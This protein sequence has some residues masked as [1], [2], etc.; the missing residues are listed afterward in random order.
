MNFLNWILSSVFTF[1]IFSA[2]SLTVRAEDYTYE[3]TNGSL[4]ITGYTGPGGAVIIPATINGLPVTEI[5]YVAFYEATAVTSVTIPSGVTRIGNNAFYGCTG[6]TGVTFPD[7]VTSF[8]D[9]VFYGCTRLTS[10][11]L[12]NSVTRIGN[13]T[14]YGCAALTS[15]TIPASVTSIGEVAFGACTSLTGVTLPPG[16]TGISYATFFGCTSLASVTIPGS[17]TSIGDRAFYNCQSLTGLVIPS[18]VTRIGEATFFDCASLT[19]VTI[20]NGVTSIGEAAFSGCAILDG[21]MLPNSV[22]AI[23]Q[24][25]FYGCASLS[26]LT[27]PTGV[28]SVP[29]ATFRGC[30]SLTRV[31]IPGSV[32][33]LDSFA[34]FGCSNLNRVYF[35]GNAPALGSSVFGEIYNLTIYYR[36]GTT[37]WGTSFD[38]HPTA[39]MVVVPPTLSAEPANVTVIAGS[40]ATFSVTATGSAPAY[41]WQKDGV[42]VPGATAATLVLSGAQTAQAG[43]YKVWVSNSSGSVS[44]SPVTLTVVVQPVITAEPANVTVTQGGNATFSVTATGGALAYQWKK[45]EVN[46]SGATAATLV[47]SNV[48]TANAGDYKVM[49]SNL[50]GSVTSHA[51]ILTVNLPPAITAQPVSI[52]RNQGASATFSVTATGTGVLNYRWNKDGVEIPGATGA[53]LEMNNLQSALAGS[54]TVVVAN[55]YGSVTSDPATLTVNSLPTISD[56]ADRSTNEDV[57][58]V[59]PFTVGDLETSPLSL[60]LSGSSSNTAL[61]PNANIVF[62]GSVFS[63]SVRVTP[64]ANQS[65]TVTITVIVSDGGAATATDTFVLTVNPVND[66]PTVGVIANQSTQEDL[67]TGAVAFA[68]GDVE[69]PAESLTLGGSSSNLTLVPNANIVF[70]GGG[71]NRTVTATPAANQSGSATITVTVSDEA[72]AATRT[73]VL[74]VN[75][76][77]DAPTITD[78]ADLSTSEDV[79]VGALKFTVA[80]PETSAASLVLGRSSSNTVLVPTANIVFGGSG[81]NRTVTVTPAA[82][83]SGSATITVTV[84]DGVLTTTDTFL[85]TVNAVNDPPTIG[86][87][88]NRS[89]NEDVATAPISFTVADLETA[90]E[91]LT[92]G[93][94]SSNLT[95]LPNSN[96]GFG[97]NGTNRTVTLTPAANQSGSTT[98]TLTANDGLLTTTRTFVLTVNPINDAPVISD[99]ADQ[100]T[101]EDVGTAAIDFTVVD[102]ETPASLTLAGSS[103]NLVLVPNANIVF[104]GS[105]SNRTVTVT[106]AANRSGSATISVTVSDGALTTTDTFVLTVNELVD[107]ATVTLGGLAA[108]YDG[109]PKPISA[110]TLPA[111]LA[112]SF[113]YDGQSQPPVQLGTYAVEATVNDAVYTGT[114]AGSLVIAKGVQ[115]IAF[116]PVPNQSL[117]QATVTVNATASSGL[118]PVFSVVSGPATLSGQ[119]LALTGPGLVV[120]QAGQPG[121]SNWNAAPPV[122]RAFHVFAGRFDQDFQWAKGFGGASSDTASGIAPDSAGN[123]F[124][125]VDFT[126]TVSFG[127]FTLAAAG[128]SSDLALLKVAADGQV[129]SA[130]RFGGSN[131]DLAKAVAVDANDNAILAGEFLTS[132]TLGGVTHAAAGSKDISLLK[133]GPTGTLLWSTRFGGTLSDSVYGLAVDA[134]GNILLTGDFSGSISFGA[135]TLTSAG[136]R[137]GFVAKLN[138]SGV[139][140]WA[141][142]VGGTGN[143]TAFAA[144]VSPTGQILVG[145]SFSVAA[146]F[147]AFSR[148]SA[149]GT[150]G[151][152]M[153]VSPAGVVQWVTRFGGSANDSARAVA[154]DVT[155]AA[156]AAGNFAGTDA[157]FGTEILAS[158]GADDAFVVRLAAADGA[159]LAVKPCG[160][161]GADAGLGLAA[162]PFG[163]LYLSGSYSGTAYFDGD[164]LITPQGPDGFVAKLSLEGGFVWAMG[165]SGTFDEKVTSI[166]A[167]HA[168]HVFVAGNFSQAARLGTHD[169]VGGGLVD[170]FVAKINGPTPSFASTPEPVTVD[171]GDPFSIAAPAAGVNPITYQWFKGGVEL[172]GEIFSS[173]E[174]TAASTGDQGNYHVVASNAYGSSALPPVAVNVRVP[175]RILLLDSPADSLENRVLEV[176]LYLTSQGEVT[177]LTVELPYD[178]DL[179]RNPSFQ[180]GP[181][182]VPGNSSVVVDSVAGTIRVVAS[183]F[184]ATIPGGK[185]WI[186]T[187]LFTTRSVPVG[188]VV[189]LMP[190]LASISDLAGNPLPGYTKLVKGVTSVARRGIPGD[191]NNNGR[192]DVSDAAELIRLYSYPAQIRTWDQFL[193]DLNGDGVLTEGDA[194][195]VLRVV[196]ELDPT[197]SFPSAPPSLMAARSGKRSFLG[198]SVAPIATRPLNSITATAGTSRMVLTR[199]TGA[200]TNK[201]L[202]RVYLDD[203]PVGQAGVSFR[204]DY[205]ASILRITGASSLTIPP[206]GLPPG[207][208]PTWNVAPGNSFATQTGSVSF[209]AAWNSSWSFG[210]GQAVAQIVFEVQSAITGQVVFPLTLAEVNV[211]PH[212]ADG[213]ASPLAA[214]GHVSMFTRTYA[215]WALANLGDASADPTADS[216]HD[217]FSNG[218]EFSASTNPGDAR[219]RLQTTAANLT[220]AGFT[221]RWFAAYGVNYRVRWTRDFL[222]WNLLP[223]SD[224]AGSGT[225]AEITDPTPPA[226]GRF[227]RIEVIGAP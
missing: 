183:A 1:V 193:N 63:R 43:S 128:S 4:T 131:L 189:T 219:S 67:A 212:N 139:P 7:S 29:Y 94:S 121:D 22:A 190:A 116:S 129:L 209:A 48:Q 58:T 143:D 221:L 181:Y 170:G 165:G 168:G 60:T 18:G 56:I 161:T 213:P 176:P 217:G 35:L 196:A 118:A 86:S 45:G 207:V 112:V 88:G 154:V 200:D 82:N 141:L 37:G 167:N 164:T 19:S 21:I 208:S 11:A 155:G 84:S 23:G 73:F 49:A 159:F 113:T 140:L 107:T 206:G 182:L 224:V 148:T 137:D 8:G 46:V 203:V 89:T 135:T 187:F 111:G 39:Q 225:E 175:D 70:G 26:S 226:D 27:L 142:K 17:V 66:P 162:D 95:L 52:T 96:I 199:L 195:R 32:T 93:G 109:T 85:L 87:I 211:G 158:E 104:G 14:F 179:L 20:P 31:T 97:G 166:G 146:S 106:P 91:F 151:F 101:D 147:G 144:A 57:A 227:Y 156:C 119:T 72:L 83:Q 173:L 180:P 99:I 38:W 64:A 61:V 126:G 186:G 136:G 92:L 210:N 13:G 36:A 98:I 53:S 218:L 108:T 117:D 171:L 69:T 172:A 192:L 160:G 222:S 55:A 10:V 68:V 191:A 75:A 50:A 124:V 132:T 103:S 152:A 115:Q 34:F 134:G 76:V 2:T 149:G 133:V 138:P 110:T 178:R 71:A 127:N 33:Y 74:T 169:I 47:L 100:A 30:I 65:G 77:N 201:V 28:A 125:A 16:I 41:Q 59:V 198:T 79:S 174:V 90:A 223:D 102:L 123:A 188:A 153:V 62:S 42:N 51:A 81:S 80:D 40:N 44:S 177:G 9:Y 3:N 24:Q 120:V 25:A 163:S 204:V 122:Q 215:D 214:I 12:P 130:S 150:D 205:P 197:P 216:D 15:V 105:G 185:Q 202:A 5:G 54:Y 184:P 220:P 157:T 145:G 6:L 194:T 78:I 114:A